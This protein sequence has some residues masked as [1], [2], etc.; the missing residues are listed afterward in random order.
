MDCDGLYVSSYSPGDDMIRCEWA[1]GDGKRIDTSKFPPIPLAEKGKGNQSVVIR[2][3]EALN[4]PDYQARLSASQTLYV[5]RSD[6][7]ISDREAVPEDENLPRSSLLVPMRLENR[8]LG[9]IQVFSYRLN[10]YTDAHLRFLKAL[11]PQ[12]AA[13]VANA[14]L[15]QR[16]Q[17][18]LM[19]RKQAEA[20]LR[21]LNGVLEQRIAA[22]TAELRES[23]ARY[24]AIVEDQ[25]EL[26]CRHLPDTTITFVNDAYCQFHG[27][28]REG[29]I[30]HRF[31]P[32]IYEED[33][34][35]WHSEY[36]AL[37][38]DNPVMT[39]EHRTVGGDGK[40]HWV[41]WTNRLITDSNGNF[42]EVQGVGRDI[43]RQK[44]SETVLRQAFAQQMEV[45]EMR[46]RFM[47]MASHDLRTPLAIIQ[48]W[49][50]LTSR[51]GDKLSEERKRAGYED[52]QRAIRQMV[53]L[54]DNILLIGQVDSGSLQLEPELLNLKAFCENM[55]TELKTAFG[56]SHHL[57]LRVS[58]QCDPQW[59]D[60]RLLRQIISNLVSNAIK[61]SSPEITIEISL[62]CMPTQ[63]VLSVE[64]HG[65]GIPIDDQAHLFETF[66]RAS[67]VGSTPGTGL[68]LAIVHQSVE[69]HGGS[70]TLES[71]PGEGT[72][73]F[74]ILPYISL[75]GDT[76]E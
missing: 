48:A 21:D 59:M 47:S 55:L 17:R 50:D 67:N 52:V 39:V 42:L 37:S 3:G 10:A 11:A 71:R 8:V 18:E 1:W 7:S 38:P 53:S 72:T 41:Q 2:T 22:R 6:G 61:F 35:R 23:E 15:Y 36:A 69:V 16:A 28:R 70:I 19:E 60:P 4:L 9:I 32:L 49:A 25:T 58:G 12:A 74:V 76:E 46:S 62:D 14:S 27:I 20:A 31:E 54:L 57:T 13:A 40:V 75:E 43:T 73:F 63:A 34:A 56:T 45:N 24:R 65:I 64:D 30:G 29:A 5:V 33:R 26:I 44:Q 51:Y 68:G 66:F